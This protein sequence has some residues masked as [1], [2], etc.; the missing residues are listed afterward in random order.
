MLGLLYKDQMT[1]WSSY[2]KNFLLVVLLYTAMAFTMDA[3]FMLFALVFVSSIYIAATLSFDEMSHWDAYVRTLPVSPRQIVGAKYL[4]SLGWMGASFVLAEILLTVCDLIKGQM[5]ENLLLNFAGCLVT[6]GIVLVYYALTFPLSYKLGAARARSGVI[7]A[8]GASIGLVCFAV[9][10]AKSNPG[11]GTS[12]ISATE[13]G[14]T[15][16]LFSVCGGIIGV[17]VILYCIS[18]CISTAIYAKKEF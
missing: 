5:A 14:E 11:T 13:M 16:L 9:Y 18:W 8:I 2:R 12:L 1:I 7:V 6:L 10:T 15:A 4:L 17:G 3:Q